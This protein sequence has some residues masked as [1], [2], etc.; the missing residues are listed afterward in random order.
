[1]IGVIRD[2]ERGDQER[3]DVGPYPEAHQHRPQDDRGTRSRDQQ[4]RRGGVVG[5]R[6]FDALAIEVD[7]QPRDQEEQREENSADQE[8]DVHWTLLPVCWDNYTN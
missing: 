5:P 8:Y 1:M 7:G 3:S 2:Q 6:V 4:L